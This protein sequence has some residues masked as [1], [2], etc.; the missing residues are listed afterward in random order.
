MRLSTREGGDRPP[1]AF[2]SKNPE[3]PCAVVR[4]TDIKD[5]GTFRGR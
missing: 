5:I 1:L 4:I 2:V 3:T